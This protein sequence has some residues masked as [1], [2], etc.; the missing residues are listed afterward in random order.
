MSNDKTRGTDTGYGNAFWDKD[1]M[2][3]GDGQ[4]SFTPHETPHGNADGKPLDPNQDW[5]VGDPSLFHG[6]VLRRMEFFGLDSSHYNGDNLYYDPTTGFHGQVGGQLI[7]GALAPV[8]IFTEARALHDA[9]FQA[10]SGAVIHC[11]NHALVAQGQHLAGVWQKS[12]IEFKLVP[13]AW[14]VPE[15]PTYADIRKD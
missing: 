6:D 4:P 5:I 10:E 7:D 12:G 15:P 8:H 14:R 13:E 3:F 9:V 1:F 2:G 11:G